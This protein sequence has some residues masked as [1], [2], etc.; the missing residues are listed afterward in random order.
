LLAKG[1][2]RYV[3]VDV[4]IWSLVWGT[5]YI[6]IITRIGESGCDGTKE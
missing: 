4:L 6:N 2:R 3:D 5:R 1:R